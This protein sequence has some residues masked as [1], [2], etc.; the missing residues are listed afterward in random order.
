MNEEL[1]GQAVAP[2]VTAALAGV[3]VLLRDWR[4]SKRWEQQRDRIVAQGRADVGYINDWLVAHGQVAAA[5]PDAEART[6]RA[7]KDLERSYIAVSR[8]IALAEA[9]RPEGKSGQSR[10]RSLLLRGLTRPWARVVRVAYYLDCA[11]SA[12]FLMFFIPSIFDSSD[13]YSPSTSLLGTAMATVVFALPVILLHRLARRLERG[14]STPVEP[15]GPVVGDD[16]TGGGSVDRT[17]VSQSAGEASAFPSPETGTDHGPL[18]SAS[19]APVW[20]D[21]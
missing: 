8:Q 3:A 10:V 16:A 5:D 18:R 6:T 14:A 17:V 21:S 4:L 9:A 19:E 13:S 11:V 1:V 7:V 12:F 2:V 20:S 15:P